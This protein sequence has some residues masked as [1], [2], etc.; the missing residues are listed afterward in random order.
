MQN[1]NIIHLKI[2]RLDKTE[3]LL[4]TLSLRI[5]KKHS[6]HNSEQLE[7]VWLLFLMMNT[8]SIQTIIFQLINNKYARN[9]S[10][11]KMR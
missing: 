5:D 10:K 4:T 11:A 8:N 3:F 9:I 2:I 7:I 1:G 6:N